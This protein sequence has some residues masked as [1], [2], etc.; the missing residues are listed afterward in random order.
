[1]Y[2]RIEINKGRVQGKKM[3][4]K[5]FPLLRL[6]LQLVALFFT[7]YLTY[8]SASNNLNQSYLKFNNKIKTILMGFDTI[9]INLVPPF[10]GSKNDV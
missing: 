9:E 5:K 8:L 3:G 6:F 4:Q 1:M 7:K 2:I 10:I